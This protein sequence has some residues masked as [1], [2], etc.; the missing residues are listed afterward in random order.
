MESLKEI[1][2]YVDDERWPQTI[3]DRMAY[4]VCRTYR[5]AIDKLK[6]YM[7]HETKIIL[8]LDHDIQCKQTGYDIAKWVVDS[9]YNNLCFACHSMNPVGRKNIIEL[10]VHYG[11]EQIW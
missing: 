1:F 8:D 3:P 5:E 7:S 2:I 6:F 9:G 4:C 11:Y 10:L